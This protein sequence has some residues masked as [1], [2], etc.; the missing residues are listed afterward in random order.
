MVSD[1]GGV[2]TLSLPNPQSRGF[3]SAADAKM[4]PELKPGAMRELFVVP[5]IGGRDVACGERPDIGRFKH[6][7]Q[8]LNIVNDALDV[9]A[10]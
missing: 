8:L 3:G 1:K 4:L 10:S 7:L 2:L 6:F 9:H 5:S